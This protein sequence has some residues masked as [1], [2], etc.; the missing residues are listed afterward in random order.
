MTDIILQ[1]GDLTKDLLGF[2]AAAD[3]DLKVRRGAIHALDGSDAVGKIKGFNRLGCLPRQGIQF[4][5]IARALSLLVCVLAMRMPSTRGLEGILGAPCGRL[6]G[7]RDRARPLV[8]SDTVSAFFGCGVALNRA[9]QAAGL[10]AA[11]DAGR[12]GWR[13]PAPTAGRSV[14]RGAR[15]GAGVRRRGCHSQG[16]GT[17]PGTRRVG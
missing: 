10:P 6:A 7:V 11:G 2:G 17:R 15:L 13:P 12:P 3:V 16:G 14:R 9:P 4:A 5:I 8:L 1:A